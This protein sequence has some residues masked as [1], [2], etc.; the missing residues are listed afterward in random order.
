MVD[1]DEDLMLRVGDDDMA[2]FAELFDRRRPALFAFVSSLVNNATTAEDLVQDTFWRVWEYRTSFDARGKFTTWLY[3]I[4]HR[5][6]VNAV[7]RA[8]RRTT[9]FSQLTDEEMD[10]VETRGSET[11]RT[12]SDEVVLRVVVQEALQQLPLDQ[13][14]CVVMKEYEGHSYEEIAKVVGCS[15]GNARVLAHRA[16]RALRALLQPL[17]E[18][19]D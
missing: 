4:A 8:E 19:G 16:R 6:V 1:S 15:E 18:G 9:D 12:L 14:I 10:Q 11:L 17:A 3:V 2:A 5:L 13:R 7:K